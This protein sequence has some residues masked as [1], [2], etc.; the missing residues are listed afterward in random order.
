MNIISLE[1]KNPECLIQAFNNYLNQSYSFLN[2]CYSNEKVE[3]NE[4]NVFSLNFEV[5][6]SKEFNYQSNLFERSIDKMISII[7]VFNDFP[8][9]KERL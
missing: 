2:F 3:F 1:N 6:N 7:F 9:D 4:N 8:F 5:M